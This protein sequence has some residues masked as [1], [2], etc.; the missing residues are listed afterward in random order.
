MAGLRR[1]QKKEGRGGFFYE[2]A[3]IP[4][5]HYQI[6][7]LCRRSLLVKGGGREFRVSLA[8]PPPTLPSSL[9]TRE[10]GGGEVEERKRGSK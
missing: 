3:L 1:G 9:G 5:L 6:P 4:L 2:E 7:P 8:P 10:V